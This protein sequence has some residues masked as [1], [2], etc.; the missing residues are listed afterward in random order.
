M[1]TVS[2]IE[3]AIEN[4]PLEDLHELENWMTA[5]ARNLHRRW[6]P[7]ELSAATRRMV[8]EPDSLRAEEIKREIMRGFYGEADA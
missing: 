5:Y 3:A 1:S 2:E 7:E 6:T 4:L 8:H